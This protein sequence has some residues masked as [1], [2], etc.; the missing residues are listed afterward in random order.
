MRIGIHFSYWANDWAE[1]YHPYIDRAAALGFDQLEISSAGISRF[2][3]SDDHLSCLRAHAEEKGLRLSAGFGPNPNQNFCSNDL[4]IT[5]NIFRFFEENMPRLEKLGISTLAGPMYTRGAFNPA[6]P[7]DKEADLE[8]AAFHLRRAA[9]IAADCGI[10][11]A[12]EIINRY[13]GYML[14]TCAEGLQFLKRIDRSNVGL[15]LDTFHMNI[16][17]DDPAQ[18]IRMAG[19]A[20]KHLHVAEQN[21]RLPGE[22]QL[23][24]SNIFQAL[25]DIAF[26]GA[27]VIESFVRPQSPIGKKAMLWRNL[28]PDVSSAALDDAAGKAAWFL[29]AQ[30]KKQ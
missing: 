28:L 1:D 10:S 19:P 3:T 9:D 26:D 27:V 23:P 30:V 17:E 21:R 18:A 6:D 22:G 25:D 7:F 20:L 24:W 15:L 4:E 14:N 2:F 8:T 11:L 13:E 16:E 12:L 29:K 5:K